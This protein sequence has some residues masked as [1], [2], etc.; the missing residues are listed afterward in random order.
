MI[1][2]INKPLL[3]QYSWLFILVTY[4]Y[5]ILTQIRLPKAV[6]YTE[7]SVLNFRLITR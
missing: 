6:V 4:L 1:G 7:N 3:L 2:I 5:L